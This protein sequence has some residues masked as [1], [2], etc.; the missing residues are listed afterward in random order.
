M[1]K[2]ITLR[3]IFSVFICYIFS[4]MLRWVWHY[5]AIP[6]LDSGLSIEDFTF[7][8]I[9]AIFRFILNILLEH[10]LVNETSNPDYKYH[11]L[12]MQDNSSSSK[13]KEKSYSTS[14]DNSS[15]SKGKGKEKSYISSKDKGKIQDSGTKEELDRYFKSWEQVEKILDDQEALINKLKNI[16]DNKKIRYIDEE[17]SLSI[18]V[19]PMS[20]KDTKKISDEIGIIDR[21][22]NIYFDDYK[23]IM[24]KDLKDT[25][26]A[27]KLLW[28]PVADR[29]KDSYK[30]LFEKD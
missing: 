20:E 24:D 28:D 25:K 8:G 5:Y 30:N 16:K 11:T 19:P 27:L 13:E 15:S 14:K 10:F 1:L 26:G 6:I 2:K 7:F 3:S 18:E 17:G 29:K 12:S 21:L 4:M 9:I 22:L 23:K